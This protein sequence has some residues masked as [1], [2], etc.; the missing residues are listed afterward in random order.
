M[1]YTYSTFV[2]AL[3]PFVNIAADGPEANA[4]FVAA[5]P[6]IINMAEQRIYADLQLLATVV[7]NTAG[8]TVPN[9]RTFTL[10]VPSGA[11]GFNVVQ[12]LNILNGSARYPAIKIARELMDGLWPND[13]GNGALPNKWAVVNNTTLLLGPSPVTAYNVEIYGTVTPAALS[14]DNPTTFLSTQLSGLFWLAA[15]SAASGYM[16]NFGSQA[17]DPKMAVSWESQY[18]AALPSYQTEE[19]MR[20][21]K[22]SF[23]GN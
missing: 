2:D 1:S 10:P 8:L 18:T 5:L 23:E 7:R 6:T 4:A 15:M 3:E 13:V 9:S 11:I 22:S 14:A 20:K 19:N 12:S 21:F 16:R 17:D